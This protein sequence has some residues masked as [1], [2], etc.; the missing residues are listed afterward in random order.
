MVDQ[1]WL[2]F[3]N[4]NRTEGSRPTKRSQ[5]IVGNWQPGVSKEWEND[6]KAMREELKR[7]LS[8]L[9]N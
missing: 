8:F 5:C 9:I 7:N 4:P 3:P 1:F 6:R 2:E